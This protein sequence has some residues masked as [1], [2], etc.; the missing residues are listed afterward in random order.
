MNHLTLNA[1]SSLQSLLHRTAH[2]HEGALCSKA[3]L[4]IGSHL[5]R[6]RGSEVVS[7]GAS[8]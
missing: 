8:N 1:S 4:A 5:L 3:A 7:F 6:A 2:E